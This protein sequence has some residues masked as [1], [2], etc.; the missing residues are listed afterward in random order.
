MNRLFTFLAAALICYAGI[1]TNVKAETM[2]KEIK[3]VQ[4]WD[5]TFPKSG[6]VNH[7]KVTFKT[8]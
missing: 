3:S 7:E 4:E 5:K 1:Q 6:K 2:D 8:Q